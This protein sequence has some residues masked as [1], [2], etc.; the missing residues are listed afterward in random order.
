MRKL[1]AELVC[2]AVAFVVTITLYVGADLL[3]GIR[4]NLSIGLALI[5]AVAVGMHVR[6]LILNR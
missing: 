3:L 1:L 5:V 2:V 4:G 6:R